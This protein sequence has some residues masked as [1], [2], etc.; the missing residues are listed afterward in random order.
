MVSDTTKSKQELIDAVFK[1]YHEEFSKN[2]ALSV[3]I[4]E[5]LPE[6]VNNEIRNAFS[7]LARANA[8]S[9]NSLIESECNQAINHIKRAI[10]DCLKIA[11]V[12]L[13][14]KINGA[15]NNAEL[16]FSPLPPAIIQQRKYLTK[17]RQELLIA[18]ASG[19]EDITKKYEEL[20]SD[21]FSLDE[22]L[23]E[24]YSNLPHH[25]IGKIKLFFKK[26]TFGFLAGTI[27]SLLASYIWQKL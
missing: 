16:N 9:G 5:K 2:Y 25:N 13:H 6:Q 10:R 21:C 24:L 23:S 22:K 15:M 8:Y 3:A 1:F 7:H 14:D 20:L 26:H 27:A 12:H 4:A 19:G 17:T 18:E 11:I